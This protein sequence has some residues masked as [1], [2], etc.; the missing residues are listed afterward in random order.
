MNKTQCPACAATGKDTKGDNLIQYPD[1]LYCH[2]CGYLDK[3]DQ[4]IT[5]KLQ[6]SKFT[7][8]YTGECRSIDLRGIS[9]KT[10][11]YFNYQNS[12]FFNGQ[13]I[14]IANYHDP[15]TKNL[16]WQKLRFLEKKDFLSWGPKEGKDSNVLYGQWLWEP[17]PKV[18]VTIV[19]GEIDALS[20]AEVQGLSFPVVSLP[21]GAGSARKAIK[22]NLDWLNKWAYVVLAFDNDEEGK[23]AVQDSLDLFEHGKVRITTWR[24]KDANDVLLSGPNGANEVKQSLWNATSVNQT[25]II[26]FSDLSLEDIQSI[27]EAGLELPYPKL[28]DMLNGLYRGRFYTI[29]ADPKTG[30]TTLAKELSIFWAEQ[31]YKIGVLYLEEPGKDEL[32]SY[33]SIYKNTPHWKTKNKLKENP[34]FAEVIHKDLAKLSKNIFLYDHLGLTDTKTLLKVVN[35]LVKTY[36]CDIII[37][38]NISYSLAGTGNDK[39]PALIGQ[40]IFEYISSINKTNTVLINIMHLRKHTESED[41]SKVTLAKLYGSGSYAKFS[42]AVIALEKQDNAV[43]LKVLANR[44]KGLTG[45]ADTLYFNA[46][47][48]RLDLKHI[49]E[50]VLTNAT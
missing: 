9:K 27:G 23:K 21:K 38:D 46:N 13:A 25:N 17:N 39:D 42:H 6:G 44:A 12:K 22:E 20:V 14:Q 8:F 40:T 43:L 5:P 50:E 15:V 33:W 26:Q 2:A 49:P 31:G 48:G 16:L 19:E 3:D 32:L 35:T 36:S 28:Q 45:Y 18:F 7:E 1:G 41:E 47:T 10:T 11:E 29:A 24:L 4:E 34:K 37:L 30:K